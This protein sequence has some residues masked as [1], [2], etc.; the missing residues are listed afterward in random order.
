MEHG[1]TTRENSATTRVVWDA[2][3]RLI[4]KASGG[5]PYPKGAK[6]IEELP[7]LGGSRVDHAV[8]AFRTRDS[9]REIVS[10]FPIIDFGVS[11]PSQTLWTNQFA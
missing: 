11:R 5:L 3:G 1:A 10:I 7:V 9:E 2:L 8:M 6:V 4:R